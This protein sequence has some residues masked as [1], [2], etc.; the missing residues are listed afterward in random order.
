MTTLAAISVSY[1]AMLWGLLLLGLPVLAH[2]LHRRASRQVVFPCIALLRQAAASQSALFRLR[3]WVLLMLRCLAMALL[4]FGFAQPRWLFEDADSATTTGDGAGAVLLLDVSAST[5]Q[6]DGGV[7][8]IQS[9]RAEAGRALD[10]L[11]AGVDVAN[12]VYAS[13]SPV[14]AFPR[15]TASVAAIERELDAVAPTFERADT[16][17]ALALAGE[18]LAQQRGGRH[19]VV[20]TDLQAT[21][22]VDLAVDLGPSR[23]LPERTRV[24]IVSATIA[25]PANLALSGGR[26]RPFAPVAGQ[27]AHLSV[28][29]T[30]YAPGP[31]AALVRL[32]IDGAEVDAVEVH[33]APWEDRELSFAARF[34]RAGEHR[35]RFALDGQDGLAADD[36]WCMVV[37]AVDRPAVVVVGDDQPGELGSASYF[38]TRAIAPRGD[39]RDAYAVHHLSSAEV[40]AAGL[41]GLGAGVVVL[42]DA[43]ELSAPALSALLGH[44]HQGGGLFVLGGSGPLDRTLA[45]LDELAPDGVAP[46]A[47]AARQDLAARGDHLRIVDGAWRSPLLEAFTDDSRRALGEIR[48]LRV[49]PAGEVRDGARAL[50]RFS[51]G[52]P[53]MGERAV[54]AGRLVLAAFGAALGDSDL[55]K[56]G[57]FVALVQAVVRGLEPAGSAGRVARCGEPVVVEGARFDP[58]GPALGVQA[59]DGRAWPGADATYDARSG[60]IVVEGAREPGFLQVAQG[61]RVVG[62]IGLHIDPRES[63][64]RRLEPAHLAEQLRRVGASARV[65]EATADRPVL[66]LRGRPLWGWLVAVALLALGLEMALLGWWRR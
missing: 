28:R 13:A 49:W 44:L 50:L 45:A 53:A 51:D 7:T 22:W 4:V 8:A 26:A 33:L 27:P 55:S 42:S 60:T 52:S 48:F 43:G 19:L 36:Q 24:T 40:D 66:D 3:R 15:M 6:H 39:E 46:W 57:A 38:V 14:S 5:S 25:A 20:L 61:D 62:Q 29:L 64:L 35:V 56:H 1:P 32:T 30:S 34:S 31:Q 21:S 18:L 12:V 9:L 23:P 17:A 63:D 37:R 54:G 11:L 41:A 16:A 2:L 58:D 47:S 10:G 65:H 59:P